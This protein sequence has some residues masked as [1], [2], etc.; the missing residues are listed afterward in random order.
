MGSVSQNLK[1]TVSFGGKLDSSWR[2]S[3]TD[4]RK[5][6]QDVEQQAARL[7]KEQAEL[8]AE[9]KRAALAGKRFKSMEDE[10]ARLTAEI[11][12][13]DAAQKKLNKSLERRETLGRF[14]GK[15]KSLVA[16]TGK[17]AWNAG[18]AMGGGV[19]TSALGAL[20]APAAANAE[21]AETVG[22]ATAY[23]VDA[24][25]YMNWDALAKQYD[26][27]GDHIGDLFEEYLHKSGEYKQ[28]GKQNSLNDAFETLG[29][30][31]GDLAG[32]SDMA[33]FEK[34][35]DRALALDDESKASFALDSLFG[36]EASKLLMLIKRSGKS[37]QALMEEQQRY[38]LVTKQG[39]EGA[40]EGHRAFSDLRTVFSSA[41]SEISGQLGAELSPTIRQAATDLAQW[42]KN[43][44]ITK[45]V[46][47][48][49][50]T[51]YPAALKFGEGVILVGKV[52]F[53]VAK[54]LSW[55]LPDEQGAQSDVLEYLG[56]WGNLDVARRI[57][58]ENGQS[59]WLEKLLKDNPGFVDDVKKAWSMSQ[60]R[61]FHDGDVFKKATEKYLTPET[62]FGFSLPQPEEGSS[63]YWN[64]IRDGLNDP[65]SGYVSSQLTDNRKF[66]YQ[67]MLN[68]QPGQSPEAIADAIAGMTKTNPAF[69]GNNALWDG[70]SV[71]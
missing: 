20:I 65:D 40:L 63:A 30:E 24:Q 36:G 10:Y 32:L 42:F 47:F 54:K 57:A 26:M 44:G 67:F 18:L 2:R 62:T 28:T 1:A 64:S 53:A 41:I 8:T 35:I 31:A 38:N 51:L 37:F 58:E 7:R 55:L 56:K 48:L 5:N 6:L 16:G 22:K 13:A 66:S 46:N 70:G 23:G 45:I 14:M 17:F 69:N 15:G 43:G 61:F 25:T 59:E 60:G 71:W 34:I 4:L 49:Q 11:K 52:V 3:A 33:Q 50:H 27:T 21:M 9:M 19:V 68:T 12:K 39:T 29:F